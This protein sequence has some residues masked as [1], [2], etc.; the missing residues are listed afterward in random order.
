MWLFFGTTAII[1]AA[2]NIV[3]T[4]KGL[5]AKWFRFI[6]LSLTAFT[7][8][9]FYTQVY[10]WVLI[11]DWSALYDVVPTVSKALWFLTIASIIINS[12]SL[13]KKFNK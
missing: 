9:T 11:E 5:D 7:L 10:Q 4:L 12:I 1:T 6:S 2:L 3:W 13:F 8:C